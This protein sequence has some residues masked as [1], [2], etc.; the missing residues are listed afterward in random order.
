MIDGIPAKPKVWF[1]TSY[2]YGV[3]PYNHNVGHI[4]FGPDGMLYV[5]SGSRTDGGEPGQSADYFQGGEVD[6]TAC[7]WRLD[8]KSDNPKIEVFA[9]GIR[10]AYGFAWDD[11]GNLFSA[12]NG[13]DVSAPEEL[14]FVERGKHY[15]FPYQFSNWPIEPHKP[16]PHTPPPPPGIEFTLPI[17]NLGPAG[18]GKP[19]APLYTFDAHSSPGGMT[20]CGKDFPEPLRGGFIIPRF[21]NLLGAPAAPDDVGFDVLFCKLE[22]DGAGKWQARTT[23]VLAPLGRPLDSHAIGNGRVLILEYTRPTTFKDKIGWLPGRIIE[24]SL[25]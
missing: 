20:W 12:V 17:P 14:D 3:G 5:N 23:T 18:G 8:P 7:I 10:N 1:K 19:D 2:P 11:K 25:E 13:P 9:R 6:I 15:G 24:L 4:A 21:G 22:K 16:Y